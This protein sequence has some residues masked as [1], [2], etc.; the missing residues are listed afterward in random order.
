M[1]QDSTFVA[2]LELMD[3]NLWGHYIQVPQEIAE[4]YIHENDKR[5][6]AILNGKL[7]FQ[8]ALMPSANGF[9]FIMVNAK[10]R[11]KLGLEVGM[12]VEVELQKDTSKYGLPM[13]EEFKEVLNQDPEGDKVFH[14]LTPGKMRTLL[15]IA[16]SVKNSDKRIHKALVIIAHLKNNNGVIDFKALQQELKVNRP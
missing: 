13:P 14:S 9:H 11:K 3:S 16:G 15:H 12:P 8:C 1:S 5:V 6:V 4:K 7:T 2:P 10:N